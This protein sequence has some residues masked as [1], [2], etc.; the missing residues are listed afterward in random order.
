MSAIRPRRRLRRL[1]LSTFA[2]F[3]RNCGPFLEKEG[4]EQDVRPHLEKFAFPVLEDAFQEMAAN[5][6]ARETDSVSAV[7]LLLLVEGEIA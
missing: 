1:L 4:R 6:I 7:V 3:L 5:Q 2:R